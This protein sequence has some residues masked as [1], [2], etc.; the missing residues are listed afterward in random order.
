MSVTVVDFLLAI[1][2]VGVKGRKI[3]E[4]QGTWS[5]EL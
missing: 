2:Q 4:P 3:C 5:S 1:S